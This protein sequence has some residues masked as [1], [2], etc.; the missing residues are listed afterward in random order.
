VLGAKYGVIAPDFSIAEAY[1]VSFK[2]PVT[3]PF[4]L[5]RLR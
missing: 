1:E 3:G 4:T 5:D 2:Y